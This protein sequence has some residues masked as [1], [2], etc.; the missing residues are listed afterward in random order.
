[1]EMNMKM[2]SLRAAEIAVARVPGGRRE[3]RDEIAGLAP[4]TRGREIER[5][6]RRY[7]AWRRLSLGGVTR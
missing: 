5:E 2:S 7:S 3:L 4:A 1:M 6:D